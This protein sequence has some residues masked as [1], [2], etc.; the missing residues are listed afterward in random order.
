MKIIISHD[1]DHLYRRDHYHDLIFIKRGIRAF[2]ELFKHEISVEECFHRIK[3]MFLF[4]QHHIDE[5]M[6]WDKEYGIPST[7]FFGMEKGIGMNYSRRDVVPMIYEVEKNN[8]SV[9]VHGIAYK[10]LE[11]MQQEYIDFK[12]IVKRTD[13]GIRMHYVRRDDTTF[14][15]LSELNYLFDTSEFN[16]KS[17][18]CLKSPYKVGDMWEFPLCIMDGYLP[19]RINEK[20]EETKKL[21]E[22]GRKKGLPYFTILFHDYLFSDAFLTMREWYK[23]LIKYLKMEGYEFIS[24]SDAICELEK[25][26]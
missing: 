14:E 2:L 17:G 12:K 4:Q 13:Y 16:K 20:K 23:W 21:L 25:E 18:Y 24:Y 9:G 19:K 26:D 7:F 1:V 3:N 5:V 10:Q 6:K 15:K 8:F 22:I 11:K